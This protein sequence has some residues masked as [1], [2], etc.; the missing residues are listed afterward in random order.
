MPNS[1]PVLAVLAVLLIGGGLTSQAA[2]NA[3]L[4]ARI[5]ALPASVL[6]FAVGLVALVAATLLTRAPVPSAA[7][8]AGMPWHLWIGG[9]FGAV[10]IAASVWLVPRLG[11]GFFFALVIS[12]QLVT[13][14]VIEHFGLL[15][16]A[17]QPA[18]LQRLLGVVIMLAGAML[19]RRPG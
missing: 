4:G 8:L 19:V 18:S 5:G 2:I 3:Q 11:P 12:G 1:L 14:L 13:A 10:F 9:L 16:S 7:G 15:G 17:R 6:S